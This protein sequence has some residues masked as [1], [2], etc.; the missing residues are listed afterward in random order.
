VHF[1]L[2]GKEFGLLERHLG[3]I[4]GFQVSPKIGLPGLQGKS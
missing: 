1:V 4:S 2:F 3:W